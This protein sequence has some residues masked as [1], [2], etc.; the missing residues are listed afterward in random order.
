MFS[1]SADDSRAASGV[2]QLSENTTGRPADKDNRSSRIAFWP[3]DSANREATLAGGTAG[4]KASSRTSAWGTLAS[5]M[6]KKA[7]SERMSCCTTGEVTKLP[8]PWARATR[9]RATRS[10]IASRTVTRLTP[11]RS[12]NVASDGSRSP[13]P[14]RPAP[15]SCSSHAAIWACIETGLFRSGLIHG[16]DFRERDATTSPCSR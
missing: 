5:T 13:A 11:S 1:M 3:D 14:R 4:M 9:P 12:T 6:S 10:S 2:S 15:I 7:W 16:S 8:L